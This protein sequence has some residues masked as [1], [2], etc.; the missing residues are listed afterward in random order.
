MG[1][2][3]MV[4]LT[5]AMH[6]RDDVPAVQ[7]AL[8]AMGADRFVRAL[9]CKRVAP[10]GRGVRVPCP[11]HR[12]KD[13]NCAVA[14][15]DG[16]IVF[17][18]HS[19]CGGQGGDALDFVAAVYDLDARGQ[20]GA[21]LEHAASIAGVAL[22]GSTSPPTRSTPPVAVAEL[23]AER[24]RRR[25]LADQEHAE[26]CAVFGAMFDRLELHGAA[27]PYLAGRGLSHPRRGFAAATGFGARY[28]NPTE[29]P[30][31]V[32]ELAEQFGADGLERVGLTQG[33]RWRFGAHPLLLPMHDAQGRLGWFQGRAVASVAKDDRWTSPKG[34]SAGRC[35]YNARALVAGNGEP[36]WLCEGPTDVLAA[37]V[38]SDEI[39]A[40]LGHGFVPVGKAGTGRLTPD[41][42]AMLSGRDVFVT[43]D[44]DDAGARGA[45]VVA[46]VLH[47]AGVAS[48]R[49]LP[50]PPGL[51]LADWIAARRKGW[52]FT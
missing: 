9:G 45:E 19:A 41:A 21:V 25:E 34:G 52:V 2:R 3:T 5:L 24:Q 46:P 8:A 23:E 30:E 47:A 26:R 18:C 6:S 11:V 49:R 28:V 40:E 44:G 17:V 38:F 51:D 29:A 1:S 48:V 13:P 12:G 4:A 31:L 14:E 32:A 33:G 42:A 43:Y 50:V 15:K 16:R 10:D 7:A 39:R 20:F 35:L 22:G 37:L 36:V 27:V